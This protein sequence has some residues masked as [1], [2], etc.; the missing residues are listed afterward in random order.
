MCQDRAT[1]T[2]IIL[3]HG[4]SEGRDTVKIRRGKQGTDLKGLIWYAIEFGLYLEDNRD[5]K[6]AFLLT[7]VWRMDWKGFRLRNRG[8]DAT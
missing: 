6:F 2:N 1:Q 7:T 8:I 5:P 3:L 4:E